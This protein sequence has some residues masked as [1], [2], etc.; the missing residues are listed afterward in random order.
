[1]PSGNPGFDSEHWLRC[2]NGCQKVAPCDQGHKSIRGILNQSSLF[3]SS[4]GF[5]QVPRYC[6]ALTFIMCNYC[7]LCTYLPTYT[8]FQLTTPRGRFLNRVQVESLQVANSKRINL[9]TSSLEL[10]MFSTWTRFKNRT[11]TCVFS[12]YIIHRLSWELV[13]P[14]CNQ[15]LG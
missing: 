1:M 7:V 9:F 13:L 2:S 5:G 14:T 15:D 12:A 8:Q 10:E 3:E 6:L 11:T 4:F